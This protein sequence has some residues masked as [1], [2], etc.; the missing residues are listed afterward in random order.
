MFFDDSEFP[1]FLNFFNNLPGSAL[2]LGDVI[3]R[4]DDKS[5]TY[6]SQKLIF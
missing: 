4:F 2:I 3:F 6:V 1:D 5:K